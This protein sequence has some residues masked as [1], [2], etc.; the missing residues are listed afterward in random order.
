MKKLEHPSYDIYLRTASLKFELWA[1]D[2]LLY[3]FKPID[4]SEGTGL[5][6]DIPLNSTILKNGSHSIKMKL[7]PWNK[8][9]FINEES[10]A[11]F[12]V[13]I[14]DTDKIYIPKSQRLP[15]TKI[16]QI[17][18]PWGGLDKNVNFPYYELKG[19][20]K[21]DLLPYEIVGWY[22]SSDLKK[23]DE[24]KLFADVLRFYQQL[25]SLMAQRNATIYDELFKEKE[26]LIHKAFYYDYHVKEK[27][28]P[29]YT[30]MVEDRKNA[31]KELFSED[32]LELLPLNP[33]E[34]KL[35]FQAEGKMVS[36]VRH[37]NSPALRFN[38]PKNEGE[39]KMEVRLHRKTKDSSLS[40]I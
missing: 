22:E 21:A 11:E 2:I 15:D 3:S 24:K 6:I 32:G 40:I 10:Y 34:L 12:T 29:M 25:H 8:E 9:H 13:S 36:L 16:L 18:T 27:K 14:V 35:L 31:T 4:D 28:D 39:V 19:E 23:E 33:S 7:F 20:F 38:D 1:N 30:A 26:D 37:D 17:K 5:G